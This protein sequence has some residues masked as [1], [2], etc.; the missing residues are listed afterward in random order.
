MG[1]PSGDFETPFTLCFADDQVVVAQDQDD[2]EYMMR[3]LVEEYR[4]WGLEVS[5]SKS[6][7]MTFGGDQ[8]SIELEDR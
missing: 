4:K 5:I 8:Q 6:E 1:V 3:K 7:K 2:A